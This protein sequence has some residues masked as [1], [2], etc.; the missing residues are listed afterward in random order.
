MMAK[1]DF[2]VLKFLA[3]NNDRSKKYSIVLVLEKKS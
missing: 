2:V 1:D 3:N